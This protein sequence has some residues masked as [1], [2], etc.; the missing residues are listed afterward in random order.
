MAYAA[1]S[2][3]TTLACGRSEQSQVNGGSARA[4]EIERELDYNKQVWGTWYLLD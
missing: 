2:C 3:T 1:A 4:K